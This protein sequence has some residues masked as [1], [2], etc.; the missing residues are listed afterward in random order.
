[1]HFHSS[2][3]IKSAKTHA[4]KHNKKF[5]AIGQRHTQQSMT[6]G[7]ADIAEDAELCGVVSRLCRNNFIM[8]GNH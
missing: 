3:I 5:L 8:K 7:L 1:M 6:R 2:Y 4:T